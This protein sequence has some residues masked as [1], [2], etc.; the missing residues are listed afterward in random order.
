MYHRR[1]E[2]QLAGRSINAAKATAGLQVLDLAVCLCILSNPWRP[3]L[4]LVSYLVLLPT[5]QLVKS[6]S[7]GCSPNFLF[8]D[9]LMYSPAIIATEQAFQLLPSG[10]DRF[11]LVLPLHSFSEGAPFLVEISPCSGL[12]PINFNTSDQGSSLLLDSN[13]S[14][15]TD[16][17]PLVFWNTPNSNQRS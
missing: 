1:F 12:G 4:L 17:H 11:D 6:L 3:C 16:R 2:E 5:S 14:P 7:S 9:N 15:Q 8:G 10:S 13:L